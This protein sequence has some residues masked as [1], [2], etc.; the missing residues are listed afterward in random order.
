MPHDRFGS[1]SHVKQKGMLPHP[2][3][4]DVPMGLAVQRKINGKSNNQNISC[5][6]PAI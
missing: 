5:F 4:I 1:I 2:Q 3:D 6:L